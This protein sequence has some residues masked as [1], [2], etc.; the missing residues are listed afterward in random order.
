MVTATQIV[1]TP[2]AVREIGFPTLQIHHDGWRVSFNAFECRLVACCEW[3]PS[4]PHRPSWRLHYNFFARD[5]GGEAGARAASSASGACSSGCSG[6]STQR[7]SRADFMYPAVHK[8]SQL[9]N[10][11]AI[12]FARRQRSTNH[13]YAGRV[14]DTIAPHTQ[15][16]I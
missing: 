6:G 2:P 10:A 13:V 5:R 9:F 1:S 7:N 16:R 4:V 14:R 15:S 8:Y 11:I 12:S 3:L